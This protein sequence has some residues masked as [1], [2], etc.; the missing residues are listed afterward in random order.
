MNPSTLSTNRLSQASFFFGLLTFSAFCVGLAPIPL[1]AW[2]CYPAAILFG[3]F[4]LVS[5]FKALQQVRIS[6]EKGHALAMLGIWT[7]G[8]SVLAVLCFTTLTVVLLYYGAESINT[9][10]PSFTH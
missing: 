4:A 7:G 9:I 5:G 6:G 10:W 2:V 3:A 1:T 8:L